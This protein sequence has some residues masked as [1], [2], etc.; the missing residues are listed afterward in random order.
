MNKHQNGSPNLPQNFLYAQI[1]Q[2]LLYLKRA[3][4]KYPKWKFAS[5]IDHFVILPK[6]TQNFFQFQ[7]EQNENEQNEQ[8]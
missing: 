5:E 3:T 1:D 8:N 2:N 6:L 4:F 7:N